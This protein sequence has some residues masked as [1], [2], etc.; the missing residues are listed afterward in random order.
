M[1]TVLLSSTPA[2]I[3]LGWNN[4]TDGGTLSGGSWL[5]SL[6]LTN[7]QNRQVQKVARSSNTAV[8]STQFQIDL[9]QARNIGVLALVVHNISVSGRVRVCGSDA[10]AAWSNL[11]PS[12]SAFDSADWFKASISIAAN[13]DTAPDGTLT[14]D[15]LTG[16]GADS[17]VA[18]SASASGLQIYTAEVWLRADSP[19]TINLYLTSTPYS[20]MAS[21]GCSVTTAWQKF[22]ISGT[23]P[24]GTTLVSF[25]IGGGASVGVGVQF[26][27]WGA[28]IAAG[29][30]AIYDSGWVDA[31]PAGIVPQNLLEWE[32]DNFWLGTLSANARAGY[33]SP[34]IHLLSSPQTLRHWR[35]EMADTANADGYIQ[36][37]RLFMSSVW[38]PQVNYS[39][40]AGLG[41]SDPTPVD[42]SLS[43]A[44]FFDVRSRYRVFNFE[45]QH[46]EASEAYA[47]ALELQRLS[48]NSGEVL[49]VPDS[50]DTVNQPYRSFVGRLLQM[51]EITQPQPST[52]SARFQVKE[53]L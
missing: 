44:E 28:S 8:S 22:K 39:Y 43:G 32:D 30:G 49:V 21:I 38:K 42:T 25:Q 3:T 48:G 13:T 9:G 24:A 40:G 4:R 10:A 50:T 45:L 20:V 7:L 12:G 33:Q 15:R 31:W 37:G 36:I 2:N 17:Y 27:A 19:R 11:I 46:I 5:A 34:F 29:N 41:Y 1:S 6:P 26:F 47:Y 51:G 53:L 52:F 35:A 14:A 18:Q 23:T 16:T